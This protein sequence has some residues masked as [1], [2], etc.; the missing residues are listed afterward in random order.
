MKL[1][2]KF[3]AVIA[4]ICFACESE[5]DDLNECSPTR[6]CTLE[7][8]IAT[9]QIIDHNQNGVV[10]DEWTVQNL[11]NGNFYNFDLEL[12]A[13]SSGHYVIATDG[14]MDEIMKS[15]SI[16]RF[17]GQIDNEIKLEYNF[18]IGHDCCHIVPIDVPE[19][20]TIP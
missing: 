3:L 19:T 20:I 7:F 18:S 12:S 2:I 13:I 14:I 16:I 17:V 9:V 15:G 4:F 5:N 11:G 1:S 10:F 8:R 6:V